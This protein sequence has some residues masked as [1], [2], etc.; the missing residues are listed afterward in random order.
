MGT[1]PDM[2]EKNQMAGVLMALRIRRNGKK[3][4]TYVLYKTKLITLFNQ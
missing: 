2:D 1:A 4:K 3:L